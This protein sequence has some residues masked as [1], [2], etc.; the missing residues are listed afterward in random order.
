MLLES[1][2]A[3]IDGRVV[4]VEVAFCAFRDGDSGRGRE[5]LCLGLKSGLRARL[6]PTD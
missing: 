6:G 1:F 5:G 4:G 3:P 2:G